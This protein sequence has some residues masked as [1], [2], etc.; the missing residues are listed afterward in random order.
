MR[1]KL[2]V[3]NT[4]TNMRTLPRFKNVVFAGGGIRCFWQAGFWSEVAVPLNIHPEKV[5][6]VSAG[7]AMACMIF[8]GLWEETLDLFKLATGHNRRNIYPAN[9]FRNAPVFPHAAMYRKAILEVIDMKSIQRIH[10]GP[11]IRI[12]IVRLPRWFGPYTGTLAGFLAYQLEKS[13]YRPVHPKLGRGIGFIPEVISVRDCRTPEA[14][15]DLILASSC[16]PPFTPVLNYNGFPVLDGG[17]VDNVPV[18][19]IGSAEG[20]TLVLL[21]R[22]YPKVPAIAKRTYVQ[23]SEP[24]SVSKWDYTNPAGLQA[25]FDLGCH[26]GRIFVQ[27]TRD[28]IL[29]LAQN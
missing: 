13:F 4:N 6:A 16:T 11:D 27:T 1:F 9:I 2:D 26:D 8:A 22:S 29:G 7:A 28:S 25:A 10:R 23:P 18:T 20:N 24:I 3:I 19:A 21:T 17:I 14:L 12:Q 5:A 15:A